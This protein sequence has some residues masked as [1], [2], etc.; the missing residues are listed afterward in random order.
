MNFGECVKRL[1]L[2]ANVVAV[3]NTSTTQA[4]LTETNGYNELFLYDEACHNIRS[5]VNNCI[6]TYSADNDI[7]LRVTF[8]TIHNIKVL[9]L[10]RIINGEFKR[11]SD[12]EFKTVK[13]G[14]KGAVLC[15]E[16]DARYTSDSIHKVFL[17]DKMQYIDLGEYDSSISSFGVL[18]KSEEHIL[19]TQHIL[20]YQ[21]AVIVHYLNTLTGKQVNIKIALSA[22]S[23]KRFEHVFASIVV[24]GGTQCYLLAKEDGLYCVPIQYVNVST[25]SCMC[26][27]GVKL[28]HEWTLQG[29]RTIW[30]NGVNIQ[31]PD[32]YVLLADNERI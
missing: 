30:Y 14:V 22:S 18:W 5:L 24:F 9:T 15:I 7:F 31:K 12:K 19:L 23:I 32:G 3:I 8:A 17:L 29:D 28:A 2:F 6:L 25:Q 16:Y 21:A 26:A 4:I 1:Q 27:E 13:W 20:Q 11:I 10:Y